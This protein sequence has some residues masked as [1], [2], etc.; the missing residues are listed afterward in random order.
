MTF[1]SIVG[2]AGNITRPS[3]TSALLS[4]LLAE[5]CSLLNAQSRL[6]E[7][8]DVGPHLFQPFQPERLQ[9]FSN[10]FLGNYRTR[11]GAIG[12]LVRDAFNERVI[13]VIYRLCVG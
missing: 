10:R 7:L 4:D 13:A 9:S 2:V 6:I 3:R 8:V 12:G 1:L 5:V 11:L